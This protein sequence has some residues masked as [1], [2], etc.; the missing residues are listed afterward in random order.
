MIDVEALGNRF[1]NRVQGQPLP[2]PPPP[3]APAPT[4]QAGP[5]GP[6]GAAPRPKPP[7]GM[8]YNVAGKLVP[9]RNP[10][11]GPGA[12]PPAPP[13]T[14]PPPAGA[15]PPGAGGAPFVPA[16]AAPPPSNGGWGMPA[17]SPPPRPGASGPGF[18]P[19]D[20][21]DPFN[22]FLAAVPMMNLNMNKQIG[23]AMATAGFSGNRY[24]SSA[25]NAAGQIGAQNALAQNQLLQQTLY[26][27]ANKQQ[28]RSLQADALG[29]QAGGMLD[30]MQQNRLTTPFQLGSYE[31]NRQDQF[32]N[33]AFQDWSQ[34]RTGWL[35][36]LMQAAMSQGAGSPGQIYQT[37]T[38][39]TPGAAN[40][41]QLLG[42]L[43]S[44]FGG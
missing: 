18:Q 41:L 24:S 12:P 42:G 43:G 6:A 32:S 11:P 29:L 16:P 7:A 14:P 21:N 17:G 1:P 27:F 30:Q 3:P 15:R 39:P 22:S 23:D 4:P 34:N 25:E 37:S 26:D 8:R 36:M 33:T 13:P 44:L 2:S 28:D 5:A 35:P 31:Q 9:I 19:G 20:F 38:P 10:A 40:W